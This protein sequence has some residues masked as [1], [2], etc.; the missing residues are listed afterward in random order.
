MAH[1]GL[2]ETPVEPAKLGVMYEIKNRTLKEFTNRI[3]SLSTSSCGQLL[4]S[5]VACIVLPPVPQVPLGVSDKSECTI[6][7]GNTYGV[8]CQFISD[9]NCEYNSK[10]TN[11]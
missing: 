2:T 6:F 8:I 4:W 11:Y 7:K 3:K 1:S 10:F 9:C 5:W